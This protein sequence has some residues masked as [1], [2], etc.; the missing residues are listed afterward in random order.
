MSFPRR[1]TTDDA[2]GNPYDVLALNG[3]SYKGYLQHHPG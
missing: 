3:T 1:M 2:L